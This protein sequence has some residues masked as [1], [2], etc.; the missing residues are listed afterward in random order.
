MANISNQPATSALAITPND[1]TDLESPAR[2][3]I[4]S[5]TGDVKVTMLVFGT[6]TFVGLLPGV[7]YPIA[8]KRIW[9]TGTTAT[10]IIA[11]W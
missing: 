3:F 4:V 1:D 7:V 2:G 10:G 8:V 9:N 6:V 5:E 11:V